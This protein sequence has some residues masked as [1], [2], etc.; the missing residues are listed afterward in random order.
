MGLFGLQIWPLPR[1][2]TYFKVDLV[3]VFILQVNTLLF[4]FKTTRYVVEYGTNFKLVEVEIYHIEFNVFVFPN[5]N[6]VKISSFSKADNIG[7]CGNT[8]TL[9]VWQWLTNR[10]VKKN[11]LT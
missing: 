7:E 2:S 11:F 1:F 10:N 5:K 6:E 3:H 8:C 9:I 4:L